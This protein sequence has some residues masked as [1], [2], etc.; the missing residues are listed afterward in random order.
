MVR[1]EK[2]VRGLDRE[3]PW[4]REVNCTED[5]HVVSNS[6]E[7]G[8]CPRSLEVLSPILQH[9]VDPRSTVGSRMLGVPQTL[10]AVVTLYESDALERN[11]RREG[12]R[13]VT[14][15]GVEIRSCDASR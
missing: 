3:E 14:S 1:A 5:G 8:C 11:F 7:L 12:V 15:R 10:Q 2:L 6:M 9:L 4:A 13:C